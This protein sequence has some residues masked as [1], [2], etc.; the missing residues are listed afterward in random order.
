M[1]FDL[2]YCKE[3]LQKNP[4]LTITF[5]V[6]TR[7]SSRNRAAP[8]YSMAPSTSSSA[9]NKWLKIIETKVLAP[10]RFRRI[11]GADV[12]KEWLHSDES[13]F[14]EPIVIEKPDGLGMRMPGWKEGEEAAG[15]DGMPEFGVDDVCRIVGGETPV[16]VIGETSCHVTA[17]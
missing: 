4:E 3:C 9:P 17:S 7:K 1:P 13:A 11:A 14:T 15:T 2:R 12:T 6:P 10:D 5:K 8:S 16:E